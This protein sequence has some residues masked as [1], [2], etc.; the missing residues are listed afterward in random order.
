MVWFSGSRRDMVSVIHLPAL[1]FFPGS[2]VFHGNVRLGHFGLSFFHDVFHKFAL[3]IDCLF[4]PHRPL[5][6]AF[7]SRL[8]AIG[9]TCVVRPE[10]RSSL[11]HL[12]GSSAPAATRTIPP[13]E[14]GG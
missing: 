7:C 3:F 14:A 10:K 1:D 9:D 12:F 13:A 11:S 2:Q 6:G 8:S 4:F 5:F